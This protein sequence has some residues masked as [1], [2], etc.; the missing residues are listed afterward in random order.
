[1]TIHILPNVPPSKDNHT[2]KLGEGT[3]IQL[4][5]NFFFKS[6]VENEAGR[7]GPNLFFFSK[8]TL[9]DVKASGM[10]LSFNI[11]R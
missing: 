5:E 9:H 11:F 6:H 2:M 8:N 7:L 4:E 3:R 10:Q 1:M